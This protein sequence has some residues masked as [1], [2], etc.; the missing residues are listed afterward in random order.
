[1]RETIDLREDI[2]SHFC[3]CERLLLRAKLAPSRRSRRPTTISAAQQPAEAARP[4]RS[5]KCPGDSCSHPAGGGL[6]PQN[7]VVAG[8]RSPSASS[9]SSRS[10]V[11]APTARGNTA[12]IRSLAA[13]AASAV[14]ATE[15]SSYSG[16]RSASPSSP[17]AVQDSRA[18]DALVT[19][20]SKEY[21]NG[22]SSD[23]D[24]DR[25]TSPSTGRVARHT[26]E[27][28]W[29]V[30]PRQ[31]RSHTSSPQITGI[32]GRLRRHR[33]PC[34]LGLRPGLMLH[35]KGPILDL[36][37]PDAV[38]RLKTEQHQTMS[39]GAAGQP[40]PRRP[41]SGH[42]FRGPPQKGTS[43]RPGA[44]PK[45]CCGQSPSGASARVSRRPG[46]HEFGAS[47]IGRYIVD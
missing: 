31:R 41:N 20:D 26:S 12:G 5:L 37:G 3:A 28:P 6:S 42:Q 44:R 13:S 25:D 35:D 18:G 7:A 43:Q 4:D 21:A 24:S 40:H 15:S 1:M 33:V 34:D 46:M 39:R 29:E 16:S 10:L 27:F 22:A 14:A 11:D 23:G 19:K 8:S 17:A 30:A 2:A 38:L 47:A 45:S 36:A 32:A 9:A